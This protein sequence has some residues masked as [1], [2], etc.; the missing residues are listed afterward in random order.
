MSG[1]TEAAAAEL[2]DSLGLPATLP[3]PLVSVQSDGIGG[4]IVTFWPEVSTLA[5]TAALMMCQP[6]MVWVPP[7]IPGPDDSVSL[8]FAEPG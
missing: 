8:F 3:D 1:E 7:A 5:L 2:L 4:K 6:G